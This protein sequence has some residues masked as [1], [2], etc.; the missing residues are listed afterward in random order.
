MYSSQWTN[1]ETHPSLA[2]WLIR[3]Y[4]TFQNFPKLMLVDNLAQGVSLPLFRVVVMD[5]HTT[6]KQIT[7]DIHQGIFKINRYR[8]VVIMLGRQDVISKRN[9]K[10]A[11][12]KLVHALCTFGT[13]TNFVLTG[14][15]PAFWD[16]KCIIRDL[17]HAAVV[18]KNRI[19]NLPGFR[20]CDASAWFADRHG[21]KERYMGPHGITNHGKSLLK[22]RI[23]QV[24]S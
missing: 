21:V 18:T 17:L 9:Y 3:Y 8:E 10:T 6:I 7:D 5:P 14:P 12:N 22:Q 15:L 4:V 19:N 20:F 2:R 24:L 1:E 11:L 16:N 13:H 23:N